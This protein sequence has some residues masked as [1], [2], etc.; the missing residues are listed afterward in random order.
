MIIEVMRSVT[1]RGCSAEMVVRAASTLHPKM[2]S[3]E[4]KAASE[5]RP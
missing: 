5:D 1:V 2:V 3:K 4:D